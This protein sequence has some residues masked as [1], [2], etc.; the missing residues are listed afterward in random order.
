VGIELSTP[1]TADQVFEV[2]RAAVARVLEIDPAS[3]TRSTSFAADL[4][5]DSLALVEVVEILE[6]QLR[7]LAGG[8]AVDDDDIEDLATVGDAVDYVMARL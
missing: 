4:H 8:F 5:A 2:L 7:P 6:E 1:I 3:V